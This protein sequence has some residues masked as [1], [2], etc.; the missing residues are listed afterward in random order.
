MRFA[1][2]LKQGIFVKMPYL[3]KT[4]ETEFMPVAQPPVHQPVPT[5]LISIIIASRFTINPADGNLWLESAIRSV[6]DQAA[7][8]NSPFEIIVGIDA[9]AEIPAVAQDWP[10]QFAR[11]DAAAK[12][13]QASALNAAL[14]SATGEILAFLEDDDIW[15]PWQANLRVD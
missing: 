2:C 10:A 12:P 11:A 4:G 14:R 7:L 5:G 15:H 8:T 1:F 6:Y 3:L 9:R 13:C